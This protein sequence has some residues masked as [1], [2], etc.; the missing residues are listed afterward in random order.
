VPVASVNGFELHYAER[1][2]G[3]PLLLIMGLAGTHLSW[4]EPF[5]D[6]LAADFRVIAYDHRGVGRSSR[7][8]AGFTIADL[9]EDAAGLLDALEIESAHVVG[10]S[11][12][13]MVAQ[14]LVLRHP[15]RVRTLVLG[16]SYAGGEGSA[17]T[18]PENLQRL[19]E[20]WRS[21]DRERALRT[22]WEINVSPEFA[23]KPGAYEGWREMALAG[24]VSLSVIMLQLQAGAGHDTSARLDGI[25]A[26][27]LVVHGTADTML[28][29]GNSR[30]IADRIPGARLVELDGVGHLFWWEQPQRSA[31]LVRDHV[32]AAAT[33]G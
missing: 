29:P 17:L 18:P 7:V 15:E 6:A 23:S 8:E 13:G 11:M 2:E 10:I 3:E 25:A 12:G 30:V 19:G 9:A 24:R 5:L 21:G 4:G 22:N 16:C 33:A 31:E 14:E 20:A 28:P 1:G 32:R 26:P 27:T